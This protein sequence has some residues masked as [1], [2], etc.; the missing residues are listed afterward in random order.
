M[1]SKCCTYFLFLVITGIIVSC[2][3]RPGGVLSDKEMRA[4]LVDMYLA[5]SMVGTDYKEFGT[6]EQ[7]EAV[8]TSVFRKHKIT[9]AEYDSSLMWYGRNLDVYMKVYD[10]VLADLEAKRLAIGDIVPDVPVLN[11]DSVDIWNLNTLL[12][13]QNNNRDKGIWFDFKPEDGY[14]PGSQFV[15]SM[16]VWGIDKNMN[17]FP[18]IRIS[19]EQADTTITCFSEITNDGLAEVMLKSLAAKAVKRV[20]GYIRLSGVDLLCAKDTLLLNS[21]VLKKDSIQKKDS[22]LKKDS[23]Y[24]VPNA[25]YRIYVD[26]I[27]LMRY[28]YGTEVVLEKDRIKAIAAADS[29]A[30]ADSLAAA[31]DSIS[32]ND[33]I[34]AL[35][36]IQADSLQTD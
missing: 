2:S 22:T 29:L 18:Q 30:M 14:L 9:Q 24:F 23:L 33:S 16:D 25:D 7:K 1:Q 5:E 36:N 8:F 19:V 3:K 32:L 21:L 26:S 10:L 27:R 11:R 4:V 13:L 15:L 35:K 12:V 31:T 34:R 28:K 6:A 20:Y 17:R